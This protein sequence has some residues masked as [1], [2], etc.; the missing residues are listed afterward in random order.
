MARPSGAGSWVGIANAVLCALC[1]AVGTL[2]V[3]GLT[4][5]ELTAAIV[6]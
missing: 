1:N 6:F 4:R 3:R 5:T 2:A